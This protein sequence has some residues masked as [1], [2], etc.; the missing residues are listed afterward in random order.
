MPEGQKQSQAGLP[1]PG[2]PVLEISLIS[3]TD[4]L[5]YLFAFPKWHLKFLFLLL[6]FKFINKD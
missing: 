4:C 2:A 5:S 1:Q 3:I 6:C